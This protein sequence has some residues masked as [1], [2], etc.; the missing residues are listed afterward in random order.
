MY[1]L[2][3]DDKPVSTRQENANTAAQDAVYAL[4]NAPLNDGVEG[5]GWAF[6]QAV[7]SY[8]QWNAPTRKTK[9]LGSETTRAIRQFDSL[10]SVVSR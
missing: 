2:G 8:E 10:L 7:N 1:P 6:V 4:F 3:T 9:G 5:T